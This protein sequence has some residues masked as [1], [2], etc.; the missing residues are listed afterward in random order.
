MELVVRVSSEG[1][2]YHF[3]Y[4]RVIQPCM[5]SGTVCS[6]FALCIHSLRSKKLQSYSHPNVHEIF[7]YLDIGLK[8]A[9]RWAPA[10]WYRVPLFTPGNKNEMH[11]FMDKLLP[12][13][14]PS[15]PKK[16]T[17][18]NLPAVVWCKWK[19]Q[20][21]Q[22]LCRYCSF[23]NVL[24]FR[25][26]I[27]LTYRQIHHTLICEWFIWFR[28]RTGEIV[29][30]YNWIIIR[31]CLPHRSISVSYQ[32]N[33][34]WPSILLCHISETEQVWARKSFQNTFFLLSVCKELNEEWVSTARGDAALSWS[35]SFGAHLCKAE[36]CTPRHGV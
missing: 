10:V 28:I 21:L 4:L 27:L 18:V 35:P 34:Q 5:M 16:L 26:F 14:S 8:A 1:V 25:G 6:L 9:M 33:H 29:N 22:F 32:I 2:V 17:W 19:D 3:E 31:N 7:K 24:S 30:M 13:R 36:L 12:P 23:M 20:F 11:N 15:P